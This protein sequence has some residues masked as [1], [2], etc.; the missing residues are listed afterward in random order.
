MRK[1]LKVVFLILLL[2]VI[3][4]A[5]LHLLPDEELSAGAREWLMA[6]PITV[7][8]E[9]N[10]YYLLWG[11]DAPSNVD[12][13]EYGEARVARII[14]VETSGT[15]YKA[16]YHPAGFDETKQVKAVGLN[17]LCASDKESCLEEYRKNAESLLEEGDNGL[18]LDRYRDLSTLVSYRIQAPAGLYTPY[19]NFTQLRYAHRLRLI[20]IVANYQGGNEADALAELASDLKFSRL[21]MRE[22]G[23][24]I[25]RLIAMAL[26][27]E[28]LH[29]YSQLV[30]SDNRDTRVFSEIE[31]ISELT[32]SERN[33]S[34]ALKGELNFQRS[35]LKEMGSPSYDE[36]NDNDF[37]DGYFLDPFIFKKGLPV[38]VNRNINRSQA[39]MEQLLMLGSLPPSEF[40]ERS[41]HLEQ[42]SYSNVTI[43]AKLYDPL[44][45]VLWLGSLP[46]LSQYMTQNHDLNGLIRL[47]KLKALIKKQGVSKE[48]IDA[49]ITT[50]PYASAYPDEDNSIYWDPGAQALRYDSVS[51]EEDSSYTRIF[52][53]AD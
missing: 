14:E 21:V 27:R 16:D 12:M 34:R 22:S 52:F 4:I 5:V 51:G 49:F 9:Q 23:L 3:Y 20:L 10:S 15:G 11:L 47:L 50:S 35:I 18:L 32:Q 31:S 26:A 25:D 1:F 53:Q 36:F 43:L 38:R 17:D 29:A 45:T 39:Y 41:A 46:E 8:K 42:K 33:L 30:D 28:S 13:R 7:P 24:L 19:M 40:A 44:F 2:P 48:N 6:E 37:D